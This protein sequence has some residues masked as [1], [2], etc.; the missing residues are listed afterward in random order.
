MQLEHVVPTC[1]LLC[2]VLFCIFRKRFHISLPETK[3]PENESSK[4]KREVVSDDETI[5]DH[6]INLNMKRPHSQ[7]HESVYANEIDSTKKSPS[8]YENNITDVATI[9]CNVYENL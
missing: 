2:I 3:H 1:S 4:S 9:Q 6:Y 7:V 5:G 8:N